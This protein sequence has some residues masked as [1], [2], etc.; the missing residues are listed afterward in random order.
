M[1]ID[2]I[3]ITIINSTNVKPLLLSSITYSP[4][5]SYGSTYATPPLDSFPVSV[6]SLPS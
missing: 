1:I 5:N 2:K 6:D 3:A 4:Y